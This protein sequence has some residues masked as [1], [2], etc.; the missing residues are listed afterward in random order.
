MDKTKFSRRIKL[1]TNDCYMI[2]QRFSISFCTLST[3]NFKKG[4]EKRRRKDQRVCNYSESL[5]FLSE[6]YTNTRK[7]SVGCNLAF[8][9]KT[10]LV[11]S[12]VFL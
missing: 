9:S 3:Q 6:F 10:K 8:P 7:E 5:Q 11:K 4:Y 12:S 1:R 2:L